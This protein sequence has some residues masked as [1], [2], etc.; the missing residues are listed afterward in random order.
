MK[1]Q[2]I[3]YAKSKGIIKKIPEF[4]LKFPRK[5]RSKKTKL[6][7]LPEERQPL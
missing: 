7:Y 4:E 1:R 2:I 6:V 3:Q 5:K